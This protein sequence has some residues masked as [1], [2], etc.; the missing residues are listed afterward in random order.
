MKTK[1]DDPIYAGNHLSR[2]SVLRGLGACLSLPWLPSL[3][4]LEAQA[5]NAVAKA[6]AGPPRR[7]GMLLFANGVHPDHWWAKGEGNN[8][9]LSSILQPLHPFRKD[10]LFL[11]NLT[12]Y[13]NTSPGHWPMFT[14]FLSGAELSSTPVPNAAVSLDQYLARQVGNQTPV[15][16]LTMSCEPA[17]YGSGGSVPSIYWTTM[18]W[19]S[20]T[21]PIAPEIYPRQVFDRLFDVS[22]LKQHASILDTVLDQGKSLNGKLDYEDKQKLDEFMTSVRGV[23][24]RLERAA[25][26]DRLEGWQPTLKEPNMERP[27]DGTPQDVR[28]HMQ[29]MIDLM[30]LAFQ[31]DKTRIATLLLNRDT[32]K[33]KFGFLDGVGNAP[34]HAISHH[35]HKAA[36]KEKYRKMNIYHVEMAA[37]MIE[38][39][40]SIDE[41]NGSLLDN[42]MLLF[43]SNMMDGHIH[44]GRKVPIAVVGGKNCD[45]RSGR[46]LDFEG[47]EQ[48]KLCN[49]HL[50]FLKRMGVQADKFG[51]SNQVL[52]G[53]V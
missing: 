6:V 31:M 16:S 5:S 4:F 44:D 9:E 27:A 14:N 51:N 46:V 8:M 45:I 10:L 1:S 26:E 20:E 15:P 23:E 47:E 19:S 39:M 21:T 22:R 41:G 38:K 28:E 3:A 43:G 35:G 32:S 48:T 2:R 18:S 33:M 25:S 36:N 37:G 50:A 12:V 13:G 30:V 29:L 34:M 42:T 53:L 40:K 7:W 17:D 11:N 49:L 24:Q 52:P